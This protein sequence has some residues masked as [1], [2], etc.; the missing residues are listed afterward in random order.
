MTT[1]KERFLGCMLGLAV[2]DALGM[3]AEGRP[4]AEIEKLFQHGLQFLPDERRFLKPG[5]VTD[6]TQLALCHLDSIIE[7]GKIDPNDIA[8]RFLDMF[9]QGELRGIGSSTLK[10][11]LRLKHGIPPE[12]A[13]E[14]GFFA[15]GNG[16]AMRIAPVGLLFAFSNADIYPE[17]EKAGTITHKNP[18]AIAGAYIIAETIRLCAA[19]GQPTLQAAQTAVQKVQNTKTAENLSLAL[20]LL[21]LNTPTKEA[22]WQIG[23]SG[24]VAETV[25]AALFAAIRYQQNFMAAMKA[26]IFAGG[27]TDTTAAI[28]GALIGAAHGIYTIPQNLRQQVEYADDITQ[29]TEKLFQL[30]KKLH[31]PPPP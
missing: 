26:L 10:A 18:E 30:A 5:Q 21:K 7:T 29:K 15:A 14:R 25:P 22:L 8:E 28:C 17:V 27:D 31:P 20:Q 9:L 16:V 6:D 23:T 11:L 1:P 13:G 24:Y 19:T 2:G 4:P 3:P 12:E